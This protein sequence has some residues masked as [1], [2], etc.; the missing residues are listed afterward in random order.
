MIVV[1]SKGKKLFTD[2]ARTRVLYSTVSTNEL[3]VEMLVTSKNAHF[4]LVSD[5]REVLYLIS[6]NS[7]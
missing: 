2:P 1:T 6:E 5:W 3:T 7:P 4:S